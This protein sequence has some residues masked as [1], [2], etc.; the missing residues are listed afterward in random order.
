VLVYKRQILLVQVLQSMIHL[1]DLSNPTKPLELY[2][3]WNQRILEEYWRQ[4]DQEKERGLDISPMCDRKNVTIE[5][6]QAHHLLFKSSNQYL[7]LGR[8]HRLHCA[9]S[10]R[11]MGRSRLS[12]RTI[13]T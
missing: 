5:K 8:F 7:F 13:D 4:G 11:N 6:S 3:Q 12:R 2:R 1:A 10:V 9:S